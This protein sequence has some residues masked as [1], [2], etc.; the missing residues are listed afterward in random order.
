MVL[1]QSVN[2]NFKLFNPS[3]C[4]C[5]L[6]IRTRVNEIILAF[7]TEFLYCT[8]SFIDESFYHGDL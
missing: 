8:A 5:C 4:L 1:V 2:F 6:L 7:G 3:L